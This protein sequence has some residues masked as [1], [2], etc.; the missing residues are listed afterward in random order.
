M[1]APFG[2][3]SYRFQWSAD[4]ATSWAFEMEALI[5]GWYVLS[6]TGSVRQLVL[7]GALAWLGAL[8]SPFLG[9]AADRAGT[10]TL[11]CASRGLYAAFAAIIAALALSARLEPWHV[12]AIAAVVGLLK[13]SDLM[14]RS[15]LVA[16]TIRPEILLGG[17]AISRTTSD[18]ARIAGALA[19]TGGVALLGMGPAYVAVALLYLGAFG[20]SFQV[21]GSPRRNVKAHPL[22]DLARGFGHVW[23]KHELLGAVGIAFLV[24]LLA[25]PFFLG[26]L[27]YLAREVYEVG[28]TGLGWLASAYASGALVCSLLVGANRVARRAGRA[29]LIGAAAW[30]AAIFAIGQTGTIGAGLAFVFIAG[31]MQN[32][33]M[34]PLA[35]VL[36]RASAEEMRGRVL[37]IRILAVCG[38]PL[39]LLGTGPLIAGIGFPA[40]AMLYAGLGLLLT[41]AIGWRWRAALWSRGAPANR[42]GPA[43]RP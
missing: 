22:A 24:N 30:F 25:L 36:L 11:L 37:G 3:R 8:L 12:F 43:A 9:V 40:T 13:P 31:F 34:T 28:Q 16:Q 21:A 7:F 38:L 27:P 35:A 39:G 42:R 17:L 26:L 15:A 29:M 10:R 5:L 14:M 2:V 19:G 18:S 41:G 20:L 6:A 4:L 33:N 23:G 1:L 32:Y